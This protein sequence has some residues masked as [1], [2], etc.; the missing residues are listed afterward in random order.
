MQLLKANLREIYFSLMLFSL[1]VFSLDGSAQSRRMPVQGPVNSMHNA[2]AKLLETVS[3][4]VYEHL[5]SGGE[6]CNPY[7]YTTVRVSIVFKADANRIITDD[8][9]YRVAFEEEILPTIKQRCKYV[10]RVIAHNYI[11]GIRIHKGSLKEYAY[12]DQTFE[13]AEREINTITVSIPVQGGVIRYFRQGDAQSLKDIR[14]ERV[15]KEKRE[16]RLAASPPPKPGLTPGATYIGGAPPFELYSDSADPNSWCRSTIQM[17]ITTNEKASYDQYSAE[18]QGTIQ[19]AW[20]L[21]RVYCAGIAVVSQVN[22]KMLANG[23]EV[24]RGQLTRSNKFGQ[25]YDYREE[26]KA[27][28]A[29]NPSGETLDTS[30]LNYQPLIDNIFYGRFNRLRSEDPHRA[31]F[32][33]IY[34]EFVRQYSAVYRQYLKG[35]LRKS[36]ITRT[37]DGF[38]VGTDEYTIEER[39]AASFDRN[40]NYRSGIFGVTA[41]VSDIETILQ[42]HHASNSPALALLY[43][44]LIRY[45]SDQPSVQDRPVLASVT[46]PP[47]TP[48]KAPSAR[49]PRSNLSRSV[50]RYLRS[51]MS[52][53]LPDAVLVSSADYIADRFEKINLKPEYYKNW[54]RGTSDQEMF[55]LWKAWEYKTADLVDRSTKE[56]VQRFLDEIISADPLLYAALDCA[57]CYAPPADKVEHPAGFAQRFLKPRENGFGALSEESLNDPVKFEGMRYAP[58][59]MRLKWRDEL[60]GNVGGR[61]LYCEYLPPQDES[62]GIRNVQIY[63]YKATPPNW[64]QIRRSLSRNHPLLTDV[65]TP[66]SACPNR[67]GDK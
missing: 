12:S 43:E 35:P 44:N 8:E 41:F 52:V 24:R 33:W 20:G 25:A 1:A 23:E 34:Y 65:G 32:S 6:W 39:V 38:T 21:P 18:L 60:P 11:K 57:S 10:V 16:A 45:A 28:Q 31:K 7:R 15:Q 66:R 48:A 4:E 46:N 2:G 5:V 50:E 53:K 62:M 54:I 64:E 13:G 17:T 30:G 49:G 61:L 67:Y 29:S 37:R 9:S 63:W 56:G 14:A 59:D 58:L 40:E 42:R 3:Y 19:S 51:R 47:L 36:K 27:D 55:L 22:L 26:F